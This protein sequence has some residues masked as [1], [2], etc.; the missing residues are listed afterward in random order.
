[1]TSIISQSPY[2]T[3]EQACKVAQNEYG[4]VVTA[5][6]LPSERDQNFRLRT[7]DGR[8]F[9]LKIANGEEDRS[10]LEAQNQVMARLHERKVAYC[11]QLMP[12]K[13]G[14]ELFEVEANGSTY[15]G[16][17][18]TWMSGDALAHC[19]WQGPEL[20]RH[21]GAVVAEVDGA[22]KG[23]DHAAMH[24]GDFPWDLANASAVI[25][26]HLDQVDDSRTHH[27]IEVIRANL[28][29]YVEPR[30]PLLEKS[31]IHN[32]AND[33]NV[34]VQCAAIDRQQV[35]GLIDFGDMVHSHTICG[36]AIAV[37]YAMLDKPDPLQS[38]THIVEGYHGVLPLSEDELAV[39]FPMACGRL[40]V[41]ACMATVQQRERPDNPYLSVSQEPIQ[42]TL[43][44]LLEVHPRFAAA[45]FRHVCG[46]APNP[47]SRT[48][49]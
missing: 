10:F 26:L 40:A 44:Q 42:R 18:I 43:A 46:L 33:H 21:L 32:D 28:A 35:A 20:L 5:E 6:A 41:S 15:A 1:M 31:V 29:E 47:A 49:F 17:L 2:L 34:I 45:T 23:F 27:Q 19:R 8:A 9:V 22:L 37:A 14:A 7:E 39:V 25:D 16:R 38:A 36:L 24:R 11:P 30:L 4:F 13:T 3:C 12:T 48:S